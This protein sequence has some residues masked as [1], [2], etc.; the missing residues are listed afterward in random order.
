[1]KAGGVTG[2]DCRGCAGRTRAC[3][4]RA[5]G[6]GPAG[7]DWPSLVAEC[8][9]HTWLTALGETLAGIIAAAA[10]T[11]STG[12]LQDAITLGQTDGNQALVLVMAAL[13]AAGPHRAGFDELAIGCAE[14]IQT[15]LIQPPRTADNWSIGLPAG[16]VCELCRVL[17]AF[18]QDSE[19]RAFDWPLAK[20]SRGHV[21]ARIDRAELPVHH[22][23][24]RQGRPSTERP[25]QDPPRPPEPPGTC[26]AD[27]RPSPVTQA[28][29]FSRS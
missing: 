10:Q 18:L 24:S 2:G 15:S 27:A 17:G 25:Q 12:V 22:A 20:E 16:C 19:R 11:G 6:D 28:R 21:H 9:S 14:R 29:G 1:M 7:G 8:S 23:T 3:A 4:P 5:R 13:R 26:R